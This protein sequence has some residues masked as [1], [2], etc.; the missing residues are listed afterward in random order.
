[1]LAYCIRRDRLFKKLKKE[2]WDIPDLPKGYILLRD[3]KITDGN[4]DLVE[5]WTKGEYTNDNVRDALKRLERT[6][7]GGTKPRLQ[8]AI[9]HQ[10]ATT[11]LPLAIKDGHA[12]GDDGEEGEVEQEEDEGSESSLKFAQSLFTLPQDYD[13]E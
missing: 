9:G 12:D 5:V 6:P 8:T 4:R 11:V 3:S 1:M 10:Q 2:G 13:Y 7:C